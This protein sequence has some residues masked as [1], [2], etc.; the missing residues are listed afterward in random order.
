MSTRHRILAAAGAILLVAAAL[1]GG[2]YRQQFRRA[3]TLRSEFV[4]AAPGVLLREGLDGERRE[5]TLALLDAGRAR[6]DAWFGGLRSRARVVVADD[7]ALHAGLGLTNRFVSNGEEE[8]GRVLYVG[9]RGLETDLIAHGF[10]H[11]EIKARLGVAGWRRLPAWFDEGLCTQVDLRAF[12][13]PLVV[14]GAGSGERIED[15]AP[16]S[17]FQGAGGEAALVVAKREVQRWLGRAGGPSAAAALLDELAA[18]A[19]FGPAYARAQEP[20]LAREAAQEARVRER[21]IALRDEQGFPGLAFG[22]CFADG[23]AG[24]VAVG[25]R[26]RGGNEPLLRSD[27]MLWGSVGKTFVAAVLLQLAEEGRLGLDDL[28]AEHLGG[29]A[30]YERLPN[31]GSVTLRQLLLHRSGIPDHVRKP[32]VWEAIREDP[33]RAW[34]AAELIACAHGDEPLSAPGERFDYADT[35]YVLLGAV[36]EKLEGRGL[37]ESV[38][39]RL[40]DPLDLRDAA[41]SD[42]RILPGLIQGHPV[43]MAEEWGIPGRTLAGGE[44]FMNP[45]FEHGGGG[46]YGTAAELARWTALLSAGPVLTQEARAARARGEP[47]AAGV[48]ERYGFAAQVW[49]SPR[50]VA[51]GHG[52]WYPGYRT[53]TAWFADLG[54][55]SAVCINTDDPREVRNLR[56]TLLAGVD[57]LLQ[58]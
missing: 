54:L 34:S 17:A 5:R 24:G 21:F 3:W 15:Y 11:A 36:I 25:V 55:A 27:R 14:A 26:E 49:P 52:G 42:R 40:L 50:G 19:E 8:G 35:N 58:E 51:V 18:G 47:V 30:G 4:E 44:F 39:A 43:L 29:I 32:E 41:P 12:L 37:F 48:E 53:E 23:R 7:E 45:Q 28:L 38:R 46:M 2:P 33:D 31:A 22:W 9:P 13:D 16:R 56:R 10:A 57:A 20:G 6:A 1:V